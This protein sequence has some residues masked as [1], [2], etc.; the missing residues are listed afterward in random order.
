[1][2]GASAVLSALAVAGLPT[3]RFLFAG[4]APTT[5]AARRK[6]LAEVGAVS[7]TLVLYESPRRVGELLTDLVQIFGTERRVVICRELTKKF[8][9]V[10]RGTLG[11][12]AERFAGVAVKGEVVVL[13]DRP[14]EVEIAAADIEAALRTALASMRVKDAAETVSKA[15]GLPRRDVYQ[16]ALKLARET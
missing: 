15:L 11:E 9:E 6:F 14:G 3:D 13:L 10:V 8:E 5:G 1:V 12:V 16:A 4:F 7:A 2:P